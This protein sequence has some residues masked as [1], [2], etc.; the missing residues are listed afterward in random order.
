MSVPDKQGRLSGNVP[1][2]PGAFPAKP[3]V[4]ETDTQGLPG[5]F[6]RNR[7]YKQLTQNLP[8]D[9]FLL[10]YAATRFAGHWHVSQRNL[11]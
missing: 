11:Y 10:Y 3:V 8:W 4:S 6:Q 1:G 7:L 2:K 9:A 5:H